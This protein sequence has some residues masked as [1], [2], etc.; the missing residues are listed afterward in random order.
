MFSSGL[1]ET[2]FRFSKSNLLIRISDPQLKFRH[3]ISTAPGKGNLSAP[4]S[5]FVET[6]FRSRFS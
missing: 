5:K 6:K 2:P 4:N 1:G 3:G